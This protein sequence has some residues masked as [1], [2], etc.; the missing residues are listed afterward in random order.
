M[1]NKLIRVISAFTGVLVLSSAVT[2]SASAAD[3]SKADIMAYGSGTSLV[4]YEPASPEKAMPDGYQNPYAGLSQLD[5]ETKK[6]ELKNAI[7]ALSRSLPRSRL[8]NAQLA[9]HLS[10]GAFVGDSL[11]PSIDGVEGQ[12]GKFTFVT[13]GWGHGVGMSQNG[14]NFYANYA[15]WSYRDILAHY[16]PGTYIENTGLIDFTEYAD[17]PKPPEPTEPPTEAP[18]E[19][20]TEPPTEAPTEETT[21]SETTTSIVTDDWGNTITILTETTTEPPTTEAPTEPPTEPPTQEPE[22]EP[23]PQ[24]VEIPWH[25]VLTIAHEPVGSPLKVIASIVYNEVGSSFNVECIK[26]QAVAVYTYMK[27]NGND[28][29]DLRGKP[30]PPQNVIDACRSVLGEALYYDG[31]YALTMF[32]ASCAGCSANCYEVF[33][34]DYPY[35]RSVPSE[36]DEQFDPHWGTVTY[37]DAEEVKKMIEGKYGIKLSNDPSKWIQPTYSTQT[38]YVTYVDIDGKTTDKGYPFSYALGLKSGKFK[39][40]YTP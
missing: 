18:T 22:P 33:V 30:N 10:T 20:P 35:L 21:S 9:E 27:W 19:P 31:N 7:P 5:R 23:Q 8:K 40:A 39:V 25:E 17:Q 34:A 12:P 3:K 26:A 14:A 24:E 28:S 6:A 16:Y 29:H 2:V 37:I 32:S 11:I 13:Y 38:G 4:S 15:G 36:Y 1:K